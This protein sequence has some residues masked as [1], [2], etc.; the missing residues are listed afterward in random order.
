MVT[1]MI[2][3]GARPGGDGRR[4]TDVRRFASL[5]STNDYLMGEARRGAPEG[6]VVV[7]DHQEAGRGRLGRRWVAPPGS[8]MLVSVLLRPALPAGAPSRLQL[9]TAAAVLAAADACSAAG[10][11]PELKWP[12]DLLVGDRKLAGVLAESETGPGG[13][14][15]LVIGVGLNVSWP[16]EGPPAELAGRAVALSEL[17]ERRITVE[18]ILRGFLSELDRRYGTFETSSGQ[19]SLAEEYRSRLATV[20]REVRVELAGATFTGTAVGIGDHGELLVEVAGGT[21]SVTAGD[22]VHLRRGD[23][24][25]PGD[26][27][28]PRP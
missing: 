17:S 5:P 28:R 11:A 6:L 27:E 20:G 7:A 10:V 23:D 8:A 3:A 4:F 12:N 15:V 9:L 18:E 19:K 25:S 2:A 22:V 24:D 1:R 21:R 16:P 13:S 14:P 26:G